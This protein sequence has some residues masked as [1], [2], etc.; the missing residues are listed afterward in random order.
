MQDTD[1]PD[2]RTGDRFARK[3]KSLPPDLIA[4]EGGLAAAGRDMLRELHL[5]VIDPRSLTRDCL[6]A[7][8]QDTPEIRSVA[9]VGSVWEAATILSERRLF[10]AVL[11]NLASDA[12]DQAILAKMIGPLQIAAP[13]GRILLLTTHT[14][15]EHASAAMRLGV[16]GYLNSEMSFELTKD[17]ICIVGRGCIIY[18]RSV[19][20]GPPLQANFLSAAGLLSNDERLTQRQ[21][22]VLEGVARGMT[23]REIAVRLTI[24]ERTVK[25]HVKELMRRLGA[26]NRTQVVAIASNLLQADIR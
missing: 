1:G 21:R 4:I 9:A 26:T 10:N 15:M 12:F 22:Q 25:A 2:W 13:N 11:L 18:P 6:M 3:G 24:S 17:A 19:L 23:N 16:D 20:S 7:A 5:L 8:L 14:D